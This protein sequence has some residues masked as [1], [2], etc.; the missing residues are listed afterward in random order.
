MFG[1]KDN[2]RKYW[3]D[4][5]IKISIR[6]AIEQILEYKDKISIVD[7]GC[8]SGE[9]IELL[10]HI[11][12][13]NPVKTVD[14]NFIISKSNIEIYK[15]ID[16]SP[17]MVEQGKRN[18]PN[19]SQIQFMQADLSRGFPLEQDCPYDIY[20]SSYCSLS[21]LKLPELK[22]LTQQ[23]FSHVS[24]RGY[25]VFDLYGRFS[26]EWPIYWEKNCHA[27][28]P[29]NMTYLLPES[30]QNPERI[31]WF[32]V[33]YWSGSELIYIIES[34]A[35]ATRRK[36]N[37]ITMMDRSIFVGRHMGTCFFKKQ[38][39]PVRLHVN[40]LFDRDYRGEIGGLNLDIDY[41]E[42]VKD[43]N[44][45]AA[46]RISD[47]HSQWQAVVSIL[48]ALM[49]SNNSE[50]KMI[51]ESSPKILSDELKMLAWLY[52]NASRFPVADFWA[53]IMG[54]QVGCVLR[55]LE[56]ALPQGLGCGHSLFCIVEIENK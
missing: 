31:E 40:R 18:Y 30:G 3:E 54:P 15:G 36:I 8:G 33:T 42:E 21:H 7:L 23:I 39:L 48:Q 12:P 46:T 26:L 13:S 47:Y 38:K 6:P 19:L 1:K 29:Y 28:L 14:K 44:P 10:T 11:P 17:A 24:R 51:I 34:A 22:Q 37:I 5:L 35:K 32:D 56:L 25:M 9:G 16:I 41:L 52:R 43:I 49:C 50:V 20:F 2:V 53:S 4:I 45:Q 27:Q 55:N